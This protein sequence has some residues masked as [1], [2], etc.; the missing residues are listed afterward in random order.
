VR[1]SAISS[2]FQSQ[3][4]VSVLNPIALVFCYWIVW[5]F[6]NF[7]TYLGFVDF[8]FDDDFILIRYMLFRIEL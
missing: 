5:F 4:Q 1:F 3:N 8:R 2:Q 7:L 6:G